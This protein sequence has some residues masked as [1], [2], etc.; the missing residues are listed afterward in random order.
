MT[1]TDSSVLGIFRRSAKPISEMRPSHEEAMAK[2]REE[3]GDLH[4]IKQ[5]YNKHTAA[6][7][8]I[9]RYCNKGDFHPRHHADALKS[10][11]AKALVR[12][13]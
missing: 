2:E 3:A 4:S 12:K 13:L 5:E 9:V 1:K 10:E 6:L 11:L 7:E 8:A